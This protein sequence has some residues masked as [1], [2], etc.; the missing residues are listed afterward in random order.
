[1]GLGVFGHFN[2]PALR[3]HTLGTNFCFFVGQTG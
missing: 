1:M 2:L 3:S